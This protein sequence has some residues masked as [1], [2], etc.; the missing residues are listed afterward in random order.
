MIIWYKP[1]SA[2]GAQKETYVFEIEGTG[3]ILLK[4]RR[5]SIDR[6]RE[7]TWNEEEEISNSRKSITSHTGKC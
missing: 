4:K 6:F 1:L 7:I 5:N 2:L 3:K